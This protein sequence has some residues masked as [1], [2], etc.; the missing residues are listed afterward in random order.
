MDDRPSSQAVG[1]L[2]KR[3]MMEIMVLPISIT[4]SDRPF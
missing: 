4:D 1:C 3:K 2:L